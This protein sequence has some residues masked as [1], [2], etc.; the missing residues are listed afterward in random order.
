MDDTCRT[1]CGMFDDTY[2]MTCVVYGYGPWNVNGSFFFFPWM[3]LSHI[4]VAKFYVGQKSSQSVQFHHELNTTFFAVFEFIVIIFLN[5][6]LSTNFPF[7]LSLSLA[8]TSVSF[9]F[10][11]YSFTLSINASHSFILESVFS[12]KT[13]CLAISQVTSCCFKNISALRSDIKVVFK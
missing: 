5:L 11:L 8:S 1:C 3:L 6:H 10:L 13:V 9:S 4:R 7:N 12:F 2:G